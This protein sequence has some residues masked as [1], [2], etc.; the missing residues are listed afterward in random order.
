MGGAAPRRGGQE[1]EWF[2]MAVMPALGVGMLAYFARIE[3]GLAAWAAG[4]VTGL[5]PQVMIC[6]A[7]YDRR[8]FGERFAWSVV[9]W[10]LLVIV[11][12]LLAAMAPLPRK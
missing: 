7:V 9:A 4:V 3:W 11:V 5:P 10:E 1:N 2:E 12:C 8:V 6:I